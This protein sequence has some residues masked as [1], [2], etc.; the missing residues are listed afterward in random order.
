MTVSA[1][2]RIGGPTKTKTVRPARPGLHP[3][4]RSTAPGQGP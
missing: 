2:D 1:Y 4:G 3:A